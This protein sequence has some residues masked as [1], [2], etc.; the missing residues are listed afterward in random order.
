MGPSAHRCERYGGVGT[1]CCGVRVS[2]AQGY[3]RL[4]CNRAQTSSELVKITAECAMSGPGHGG[5]LGP[6]PAGPSGGLAGE[7]TKEWL[8]K[9]PDFFR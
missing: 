2:R 8:R 5:A 7:S 9:A 4:L 3:R 1:V 6:L